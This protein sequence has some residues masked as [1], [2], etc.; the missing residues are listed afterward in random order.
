MIILC[1]EKELFSNMFHEGYAA[2][3]KTLNTPSTSAE[4]CAG[5]NASVKRSPNKSLW[6]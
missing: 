5:V 1:W 4:T 6:K 3:R 2:V